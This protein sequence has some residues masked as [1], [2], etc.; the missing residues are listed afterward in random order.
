MV[1][2]WPSTRATALTLTVSSIGV[3][4]N[5][6]SRTASGWKPFF[7]SMTSCR[8]LSPSVRSTTS[9]MPCSFLD[10]TASL[11]RSM[12][13]SGPTL[14]GSSV[15]TMPRRRGVICSTRVR[16]RTRKLPRPVS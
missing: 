1:C 7:T 9:E 13:R 14:K 6:C 12:M 5:R 11:I 16:A 15:T 10:C 4:L 3:S 8:P 2:G